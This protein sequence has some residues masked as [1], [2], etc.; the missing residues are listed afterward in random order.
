MKTIEIGAPS[1]W[2][3]YLINRDFSSLTDQDVDDCNNYLIKK[4][5][6]ISHCVGAEEI[7]TGK[8]EGVLCDLTRYTFLD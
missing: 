5:C 1:L 4:H 2:A 7:G 8:F 6:C 3:S